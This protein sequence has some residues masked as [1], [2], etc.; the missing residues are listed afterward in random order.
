[1]NHAQYLSLCN[2][3]SISGQKLFFYYSDINEGEDYLYVI[4]LLLTDKD[5]LASDRLLIRRLLIDIA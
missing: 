4:S 2:N 1:M 5:L 3:L